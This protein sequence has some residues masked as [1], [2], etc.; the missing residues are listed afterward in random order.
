[1]RITTTTHSSSVVVVNF[2]TSMLI[3]WSAFLICL[4]SIII[5]E[6][7]VLVIVNGA[8]YTF[9]PVNVNRLSRVHETIGCR[10]WL[11]R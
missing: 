1:M 9:E 4:K 10:R 2:L 8:S 3:E 7:K 11:V 6:N 5:H